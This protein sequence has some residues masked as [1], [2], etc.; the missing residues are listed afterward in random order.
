MAQISVQFVKELFP[1][2]EGG[3]PKWLTKVGNRLFFNANDFVAR[4]EL[5]VSDGTEMGTMRVLD[6]NTIGAGS[7]LANPVDV[8]DTLFFAAD[9]EVSG[10]ELWKS[11]GTFTGTV[12]VKDIG[13]AVSNS[14]S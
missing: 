14:T 8:N 10:A 5:W 1:S 9:D 13:P 12:R 2:E 7:E 4:R 11:D 3:S 6:I